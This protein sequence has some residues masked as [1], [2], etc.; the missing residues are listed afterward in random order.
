MVPPL[1]GR[2]D[3]AAAHFNLVLAGNLEMGCQQNGT[4]PDPGIFL[5]VGTKKRTLRGFDPPP[6]RAPLARSLVTSS[7]MASKQIF[8]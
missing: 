4:M 5:G 3:Y 1:T 8:V 7:N 6:P 2:H